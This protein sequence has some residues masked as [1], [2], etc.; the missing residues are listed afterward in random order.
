LDGNEPESPKVEAAH[1]SPG[2]VGNLTGAIGWL[3]SSLGVIGALLYACGYLIS[4]AQ[5]HLLGLGRLMSYG[6][7]HYVQEGGRF[8]ADTSSTAAI[9]VALFS[10]MLIILAIL[11]FGATILWRKASAGH[12]GW[13][14][15]IAPLRARVAVAWRGAAYAI[16]LFLLLYHYGDAGE[17]GRPLTLGNVLFTDPSAETAPD[18]VKMHKF[19]LTGQSDFFSAA[20]ENTLLTYL[21][22]GLLFLACH[23]VTSTWRWRRLAIAPFVLIFALYSLLFPMLYGVLKS[24]VE[25]PVVMIWSG[26]GAKSAE[27]QRSFLLNLGE[28]EAVLYVAAER[29]VMWRRLDQIS[30]LDVIGSAPIL[31]EI[32]ARKETP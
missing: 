22:V 16:L 14:R 31:K 32:S 4:I 8:L 24:P 23:Y 5:L 3:A 25:F 27:G 20:F 26:D 12:Y 21:A 10:P 13:M 18:L 6:H 30:R 15:R 11:T 9:I 17:F 29:K 19:L 28:H 7:D 2:I 1:R